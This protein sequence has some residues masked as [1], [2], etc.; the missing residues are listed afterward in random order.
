MADELRKVI[1]VT[2]KDVSKDII[3]I[4]NATAFPVSKL[5]S[6]SVEL[7]RVRNMIAKGH[8]SG[9]AGL[10]DVPKFD[11]ST[12]KVD[13]SSW[14][15]DLTKSNESIMESLAPFA[16]FQ[17]R[18]LAQFDEIAKNL[19]KSAACAYPSNWRTDDGVVRFPDNLKTILID[20]GVPLAWVPPTHVLEKLFAAETSGDRNKILSDNWKAIVAECIVG[21]NSVEDEKFADYVKFALEAA[22]ALDEGKW[23]ASQALSTN[24]LDSFLH[25]EFTADARKELTNQ[26]HR[27]DWEK[28]PIRVALVVGALSGGYA[29]YRPKNGKGIPKQFSRH[30]SVHGL[31]SRQYTRLNAVIALMNVV[32]LVKVA[33]TDLDRWSE[34]EAGA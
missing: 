11:A 10:N 4:I 2:L 5:G 24:I 6:Q 21:L 15:P 3:A 16:E 8:K 12:L 31:S 18:Y 25:R 33:E 34:P 19:A 14:L 13:F 7:T 30:A 26:K 9:L 20:E 29:E 22:E 17:E 1:N 28:F 32:G 27:V 23:K